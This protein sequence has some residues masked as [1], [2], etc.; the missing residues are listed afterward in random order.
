MGDDPEREAQ[1]TADALSPKF[2]FRGARLIR[3]SSRPSS[4]SRPSWGGD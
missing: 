3:K 4:A 1:A 2:S